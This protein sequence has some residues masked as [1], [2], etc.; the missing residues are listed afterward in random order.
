[1]IENLVVGYEDGINKNINNT[2]TDE[3]R[4]TAFNRTVNIKP[5]TEIALFIGVPPASSALYSFFIF[6][7]PAHGKQSEC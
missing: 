3:H 7:K 1:M 6:T 2:A 4:P 5:L